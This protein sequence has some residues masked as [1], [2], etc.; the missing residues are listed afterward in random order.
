MLTRPKWNTSEF[1]LHKNSLKYSPD[2][3][4]LT[5]VMIT[6][7]V[8]VPMRLSQHYSGP[9]NVQPKGLSAPALAKSM[10]ENRIKT[11][12]NLKGCIAQCTATSAKLL[13]ARHKYCAACKR[14]QRRLWILH[15]RV[16]LISEQ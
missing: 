10:L 9:I 13:A 6:A 2:S 7:I 11:Y 4:M 1:W 15:G 14:F 16:L 3:I 12:A 8:Y 5:T